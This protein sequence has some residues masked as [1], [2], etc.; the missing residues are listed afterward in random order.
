MKRNPHAPERKALAELIREL[1]MQAGMD[2][3]VLAEKLGYS[4]SRVSKLE[5]GEQ[6]VDLVEF[7]R[8]CRVVG[9]APTKALGD[10]LE[11]VGTGA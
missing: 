3:Y 10:L 1:R 11:R 6:M 2:Q 8:I 7:L 9:V 4:Q 5:T